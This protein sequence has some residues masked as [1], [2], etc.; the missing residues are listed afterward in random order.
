MQ[1]DRPNAT[2]RLNHEAFYKYASISLAWIVRDGKQYC[3]FG[4]VE[5]V[6]NENVAPEPLDEMVKSSRWSGTRTQLFVKRWSLSFS[7]ALNWN[8][9]CREDGVSIPGSQKNDRMISGEVAEEPAWPALIIDPNV[10]F[11]EAGSRLHSRYDIRRPPIHVELLMQQDALSWFSERLHFDLA[12]YDENIGSIHLMLPNPILR[13]LNHRLGQNESGEE[14]SEIELILR[15]S[16]SFK[17]LS[18]II[19]ERRV[20]GPVDIRTILIDSPFIRVYHNGRVEKVGLALR[21]SSLGLLEYSEPL[22]FLRSIALNMSVAEGVKR[23]TPSLDTAADTPFE[24]RMQRPISDS[25]FG[26]SG[27]KDTSATHLLRANQRR[28]KIAV[29]E[30]YGQKLFQ[31]NKIAARLTIRALIGSARERV[32]IFDPY[33]GSID[34]LNFALATRWIGASVFIIT[35]AMHLKNKDQNNI[36]NGDVLEKQLK[37]WP[38]DHHID[39]YVLTGTPPQ[40]HDRFLVVDDAVWFSGNSLHSLGERM[41]L[42]IRLP[43]PEPILDALLEMK[44]GQR[45]SPFSKWIKARKKERNGPES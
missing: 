30:R 35:S 31:D 20:H 25:V 3:V 23:I 24:V 41:S 27:S 45:C 4:L 10:P 18:L 12:A 7:D 32:M 22:P 8:E 14:F 9:K 2:S 38:K 1:I 16:Q 5:A 29:A 6:P 42:I 11:S 39:V 44:N 28:E 26:E 40:L 43:S 21:H 19:E 17:D 36:E 33:L 34:L 15:S 13:K 37:K